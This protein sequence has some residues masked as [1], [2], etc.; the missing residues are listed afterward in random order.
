MTFEDL[1]PYIIFVSRMF[2][3]NTTIIENTFHL[4]FIYFHPINYTQENKNA[5]FKLAINN[6]LCYIKRG[7]AVNFI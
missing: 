3:S 7:F 6:T 2:I 1:V 5:Q 4:L